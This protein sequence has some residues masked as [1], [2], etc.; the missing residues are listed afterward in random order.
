MMKSMNPNMSLKI[1]LSSRLD[2]IKFRGIETRIKVFL[3]LSFFMFYSLYRD[4]KEVN[5]NSRQSSKL[6]VLFSCKWL[7]LWSL[8]LRNL[9]CL[10]NS[11]PLPRKIQNVL[12]RN[13]SL[14]LIWFLSRWTS[15]CWKNT[16]NFVSLFCVY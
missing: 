9:L 13:G 11:P 8:A 14:T 5:E 1:T 3:L 4:E 16:L 7:N 2:G 6:M 10:F 12:K 15:C